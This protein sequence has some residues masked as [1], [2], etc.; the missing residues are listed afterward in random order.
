M[1][2]DVLGWKSN[3]LISVMRQVIDNLLTPL[4]SLHPTLP[5]FERQ[6]STSSCVTRFGYLLDFGQVYKAFGNNY[7]AQISHILRQFL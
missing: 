5:V 3:A 2:I 4:P 1:I 6:L 7:L